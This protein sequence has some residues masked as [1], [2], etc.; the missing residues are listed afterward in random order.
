MV[1]AEAELWDEVRRAYER[2][3]DTVSAICL[4]HAIS[5]SRLRRRARAQ[6]W[7]RAGRRKSRPVGPVSKA[8]S[9]GRVEHEE[10]G[11]P[12]CSNRTALVRRLYARLDHHMTLMEQDHLDDGEADRARRAR[13]L[14]TLT[15]T[16]E[17]LIDMERS[18]RQAD[19]R[20]SGTAAADVVA[21]GCDLGQL[22]HDLAQRIAHFVGTSRIVSF[23]GDS[24][25]D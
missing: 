17:K 12:V 11:E 5:E 14:A 22:R 8:T 10:S 16:L 2:G 18:L 20:R 7:Q 1:S 13:T 24:E 4:K 9:S 25:P 23:S 6:R 21:E 3:E 19:E 15:R